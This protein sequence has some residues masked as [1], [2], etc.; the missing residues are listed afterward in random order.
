[1][2]AEFCKYAEVYVCGNLQNIAKNLAGTICILK[3]NTGRSAGKTKQG[4]PANSANSALKSQQ[5]DFLS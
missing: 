1:V 4:D 3:K 5:I 2:F